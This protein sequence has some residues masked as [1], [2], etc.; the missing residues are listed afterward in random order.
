MK[1]E[2]IVLSFV[3]VI[4][5]LLFAGIGF[6]IYQTTKAISPDSSKKVTD[7]SLSP[8]PKPNVFLSLREPVQESVST[9][10]VVTVSGKT[11]SDA[12][13]V[14]LTESSEEIIKPTSFGDFSTEIT[15]EEGANILIVK[16]ILP[17]GEDETVQRVINYY[18]EDF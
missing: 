17:N 18:A 3:A 12:V 16:A 14:V 10:K 4:I 9:K 5:G 7:N 15:L 11:K 13:I 6:Y 8:T 1:Q 2:K